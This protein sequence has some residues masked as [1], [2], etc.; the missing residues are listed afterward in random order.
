[1]S[2]SRLD[3]W[4]DQARAGVDMDDARWD[5]MPHRQTVKITPTGG[6]PRPWKA[7]CPCGAEH[8]FWSHPSADAWAYAHELVCDG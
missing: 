1:M 5:V 4:S 2:H 3:P 7:K 6:A 8:F